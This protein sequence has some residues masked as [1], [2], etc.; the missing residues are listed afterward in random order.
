MYR[1]PPAPQFT[2]LVLENYA[3]SMASPEW[4]CR[5]LRS[6]GVAVDDCDDLWKTTW[7]AFWRAAAPTFDRVLLWDAPAAV[8]ASVPAD[9]RVAFQR[10]ELV[11]LARVTR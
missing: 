2:Q 9:Y 5:S 8:L 3:P 11:I 1:R 4:L 7:A 6:G 10:D